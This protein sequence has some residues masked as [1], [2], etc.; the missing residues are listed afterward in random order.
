M[1]PMKIMGVYVDTVDIRII[2]LR[3]TELKEK[4]S[5]PSIIT[6]SNKT[7]NF[8]NYVPFENLFSK[9]KVLFLI[10]FLWSTII[11]ER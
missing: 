9:E 10:L 8:R 5:Y 1:I 6:Y 4:V 11:I 3:D 7:L 2:D